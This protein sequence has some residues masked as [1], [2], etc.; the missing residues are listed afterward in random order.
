MHGSE[1]GTQ[2]EVEQFSEIESEFL[3]RV[4]ADPQCNACTV[5]RKSR[6]YS[7]LLH[8]IWE[9][10][11]GWVLTHRNSHKSRHLDINP[12][13]SLAYIRGHIQKPLYVDC[14]AEWTEE[15]DEKRR[16]WELV[17]NTP[18]PVGFDPAPDFVD[19]SHANFGLLR[20]T[21][22]RIVLVDF[23]APSLDAGQRVWRDR[24]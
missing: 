14:V 16:V 22:W 13:V 19:P 18:E 3:A 23:P 8:P 21:P 12:H 9:D 17:S 7:R 15:L 1:E 5:D 11:T 6:P 20:L 4:R 10:Q 24:S 2:V